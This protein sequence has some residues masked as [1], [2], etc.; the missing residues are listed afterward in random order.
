LLAIPWVPDLFLLFLFFLFLF[1][2]F[3]GSVLLPQNKMNKRKHT[4]KKDEKPRN[5]RKA[6][7]Y[8]EKEEET[9]V[10]EPFR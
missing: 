9:Q 8:T 4:E 3:C 10:P 7:K 6:R 2:L 5:T 1:I